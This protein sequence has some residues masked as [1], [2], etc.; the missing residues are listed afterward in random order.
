M[1]RAEWMATSF[2]V[3]S[4]ESTIGTPINNIASTSRPSPCRI[5]DCRQIALV[6]LLIFTLS[7]FQRRNGAG[8][9]CSS[10]PRVN[11]F[12]LDG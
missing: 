7:V 10:F 12:E 11:D 2:V 1:L 4:H 3:I 8:F 9:L 6:G 5:R